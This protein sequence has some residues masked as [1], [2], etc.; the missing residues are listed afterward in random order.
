MPRASTSRCTCDD[1]GKLL[2]DTAGYR[3]SA[4]ARRRPTDDAG[5]RVV[6]LTSVARAISSRARRRSAGPL[7]QQLVAAQCR[8]V[9]LTESSGDREVQL[10]VGSEGRRRSGDALGRFGHRRCSPSGQRMGLQVRAA[11]RPAGRIRS[12]APAVSSRRARGAFHVV[13][14]G[15]VPTRPALKPNAGPPPQ[16]PPLVSRGACVRGL[17]DGLKA[18]PPGHRAGQDALRTVSDIRLP[19]ASRRSP[20]S[21]AS[22][23]RHTAR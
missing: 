4:S 1:W 22:G 11:G 7:P 15:S 12:P 3:L 16:P 8:P 20:F 17:R 5:R 18:V 6:A 13:A 9:A 2:G 19:S 23:A 10:E 21:A 14:G